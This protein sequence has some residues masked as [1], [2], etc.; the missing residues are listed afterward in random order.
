FPSAPAPLFG[1]VAS[2]PFEQIRAAD[3]EATRRALGWAPS[4]SLAEGLG[5]TVA[6]TRA[7]QQ[8]AS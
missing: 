2:R 3:V 1:S 6:W 5:A 8:A 7:S 4:V